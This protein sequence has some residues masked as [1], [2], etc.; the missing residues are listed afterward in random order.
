MLSP[1][2]FLRG[3]ET[4]RSMAIIVSEALARVRARLVQI[5][6]PISVSCHAAPPLAAAGSKHDDTTHD[7]GTSLSFGHAPV[8]ETGARTNHRRHRRRSHRTLPEGA[9]GS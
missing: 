3:C 8:R 7:S 1:R 2:F 9:E 4:P 6:C 5:Q